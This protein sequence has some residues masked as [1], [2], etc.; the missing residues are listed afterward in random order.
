MGYKKTRE[1]PEELIELCG[2]R[3]TA[4]LLVQRGIDTVAKAKDFLNPDKMKISKP[5]A[6]VDMKKSVERIARAITDGEKSLF[7]VI[8]TVT[9]LLLLHFCLKH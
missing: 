7:M 8:L 6:F 2:S 5:D 3:I 1:V 9:G 4:E